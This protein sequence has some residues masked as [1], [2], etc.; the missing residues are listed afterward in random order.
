MVIFNVMIYISEDDPYFNTLNGTEQKP[1]F[2]LAYLIMSLFSG[3]EDYSKMTPHSCYS[4]TTA[5]ISCLLFTF[6]SIAFFSFIK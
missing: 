5:M 3:F 6:V 1:Y 2:P 4:S